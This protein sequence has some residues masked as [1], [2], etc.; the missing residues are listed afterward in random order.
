MKKTITKVKRSDP[1]KGVIKVKRTVKY[2]PR[3]TA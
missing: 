2:Q 3:K 1:R